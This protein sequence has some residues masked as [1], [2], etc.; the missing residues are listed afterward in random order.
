MSN[1]AEDVNVVFAVE[2]TLQQ[3]NFETQSSPL[4]LALCVPLSWH[5]LLCLPSNPVEQTEMNPLA[6]RQQY[7]QKSAVFS[8]A[9]QDTLC[10]ML[11]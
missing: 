1:I 4:A 9:S 10:M 8:V 11:G 7:I 3:H 5:M 6:R 2:I